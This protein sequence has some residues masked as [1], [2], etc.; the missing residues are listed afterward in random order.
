MAAPRDRY[1]AEG[2]E[3]EFEPGSHGSVLRNLRG[4]HSMRAMAQAESEA[5]LAA[6]MGLQ[7]G[8]PM[9]EFSGIRGAAK[10]RYI[11]AIHAAVGRDYGP[12]AA[13][14]RAVIDRTLRRQ[15]SALRG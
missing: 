9:L 10:R 5:L 13:V 12:I 3:A 14:F 7:A 8:L 15:A 4:I 6:L 2:V 11:A 1:H